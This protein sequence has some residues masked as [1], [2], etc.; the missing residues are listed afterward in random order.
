M[1]CFVMKGIKY[2]QSLSQKRFRHDA[3]H[4]MDPVYIFDQVAARRQEMN[5]MAAEVSKNNGRKASFARRMSVAIRGQHGKGGGKGSQSVRKKETRIGHAARRLSTTLLPG[6]RSHV[7]SVVGSRDTVKKKKKSGKGKKDGV[8]VSRYGYK[9]GDPD[10]NRDDM[11]Q[12][13]HADAGAEIE[14]TQEENQ[15]NSEDV[16]N[17]KKKKLKSSDLSQEKSSS[18]KISKSK[19]TQIHPQDD[20][21]GVGLGTPDDDAAHGKDTLSDDLKETPGG[22]RTKSRTRK[23]EKK[24][25]KGGKLTGAVRRMSASLNT[26]MTSLTKKSSKKKNCSQ[27]YATGD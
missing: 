1:S 16:N 23:S 24:S 5:I 11:G 9:E 8:V 10:D 26:S 6:Q 15:D 2:W 13:A 18:K 19:S 22:S 12:R 3:K 27:T 21:L 20:S 14:D 7:E 4:L 17:D 25:K